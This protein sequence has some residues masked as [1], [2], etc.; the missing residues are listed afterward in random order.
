MRIDV[1][2]HFQSLDFIKHLQGRSALP[3]TVFEG[4]TYTVQCAMGLQVPSLPILMDMEAKLRETDRMR[5][6]VS[7]LS[8]GLVLGPDVLEGEEADEWAMRIND[9]LARILQAYPGRFLGLGTIGFGDP[10]RATAEVDR[11]I[12]QLGFKGIQIFSNVAH[13]W[14]DSPAFRP[15][16]QE[17]G[18]LGVPI[19]LHPA[20]PPNSDGLTRGSLL[21]GLGAPYESSLNTLRLIQC[22]LFDEIPDLKVIVSHAGGVLP[23]L[24]GR[25]EVYA[26]PSPLD[27]GPSALQHPLRY[28]LK[29][30][31]VDT[32]CYHREALT[33]CHAVMGAQQMLYGTDHPFG[34][35]DMPAELIEQL[36]CPASERELIYHG[37]AERLFGLPTHVGQSSA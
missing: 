22:G 9:D 19:H 1:H 7:V 8:H 33:C 5:I 27:P 23:Y 32:V 24:M 20:V 4:G 3:R 14:L 29:N 25:L 30:L 16:F 12:T 10:R 26:P 21:I 36:D 35:P 6:A 15:V 34:R 37:T 2:T 28:Y 31:Y 11:C 17:I 18:R 13:Q